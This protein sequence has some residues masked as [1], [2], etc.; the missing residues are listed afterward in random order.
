MT[1][2][3][4][5]RPQEATYVVGRFSREEKQVERKRSA[6]IV[7][8]NPTVNYLQPQVGNRKAAREEAF[9]ETIYEVIENK[10][11]DINLSVH[12]LCRAVFLSHTQAYRK[13]KAITG[14]TPTL[15][16]RAYRLEKAVALLQ[17]TDLSVANIAYDVGFSD[18]NYFSRA[19]QQEYNCTPT[20]IR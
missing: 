4:Q 6:K 9:M 3:K 19:F 10:I 14:L 15:L 11:D 17:N 2:F 20:S 18:P 7:S 8:I 1:F 16:I 13:I 12:D 5:H